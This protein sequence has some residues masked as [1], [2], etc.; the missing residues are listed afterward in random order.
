MSERDDRDDKLAALGRATAGLTPGAG[1][2]D[3]VMARI[4]A[5]RRDREPAGLDTDL[6]RLARATDALAPSDD[7]TSRVMSAV[8][9]KTDGAR[10]SRGAGLFDALARSGRAGLFFAA[11]VAAIA[12][13]YA[14]WT[15]TRVYDESLVTADA[16]EMSE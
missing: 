13:L 15:E 3:A 8:A 9:P 1:L 7:F 10:S 16:V 5:A 12:V 14:S 11:A 6:A 4:E 2:T